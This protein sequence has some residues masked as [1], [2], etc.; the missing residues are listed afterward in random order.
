MNYHQCAATCNKG[1][2]S[3]QQS[4]GKM[5]I[6]TKVKRPKKKSLKAHTYT[7]YPSA[8]FAALAL[9]LLIYFW[10]AHILYEQ[11]IFP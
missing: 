8:L 10:Y 7:Q 1:E 4:T 9:Y 3:L 2:D 11:A 6:Y 5:C